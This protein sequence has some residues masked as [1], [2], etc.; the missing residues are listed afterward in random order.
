MNEQKLLKK[1]NV[2]NESANKKELPAYILVC[3]ELFYY[4]LIIQRLAFQPLR[5]HSSAVFIVSKLYD[6]CIICNVD[7]SSVKTGSCQNDI[8]NFK[9]R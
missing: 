1:K 2:K 6:Y 3:Q 8:A 9:C 5:L 7:N 4:I